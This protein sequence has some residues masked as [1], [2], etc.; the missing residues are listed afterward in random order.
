MHLFIP[1]CFPVNFIEYSHCLDQR[2]SL[3]HFILHSAEIFPIKEVITFI[4]DLVN[5]YVGLEFLH[6]LVREIIAKTKSNGGIGSLWKMLLYNFMLPSNSFAH[7]GPTSYT[8]TAFSRK[9]IFLL[10]PSIR[11]RFKN[12]LCGIL[13]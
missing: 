1:N 4:F 6:I 12:Q 2:V 8:V 5:S 10:T 13:S 9:F 3:S 11:R 7:V